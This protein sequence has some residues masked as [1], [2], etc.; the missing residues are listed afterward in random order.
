MTGAPA[1]MWRK[2]VFSKSPPWAFWVGGLLLAAA[3]ADRV[4]GYLPLTRASARKIVL[5]RVAFVGLILVGFASWA[6]GFA[7]AA[8]SNG[9]LY[10]LFFLLGLG[11]LFGGL[12]G[13][14]LGRAAMGPTGKLLDQTPGQY[15]R[16]I[17]LG[18]VH[19]AFVTA[20]QQ[21]QHERYAQA[22]RQTAPSQPESK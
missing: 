15:Q 21:H 22:Y 9:G 2:F 1:E 20:V 4:S 5:V 18:N 6:I 10:A 7:V 14:L 13:L 17:E 3:L 11:A 16:L 8:N 19:P 12:I